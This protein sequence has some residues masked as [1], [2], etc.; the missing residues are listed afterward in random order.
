MCG[1]AAKTKQSSTSTYTPTAQASGVYNNVLDRA[2]TNA[3]QAY[4][5]AM[6]KSIAAFNPTQQQAQAA[7]QGNQ[8]AW[9]GD[10]GQAGD[11]ISGAGAALT[12]DDISRYT[13]PWQQQVVDAAMAKIRDQDA[14]QQREFT[15]G[16]VSQGG[17]GGNGVF[18][19]RAQ[20]AA[21]Q[22]ENRNA[23]IA[24]LMSQGFT[25][26][27]AAAQAD[28]TR[29][30]AA[31]QSMANLGAQRSQ[32]GYNDAAALGASGQQQQQQTQAELDA[33]QANAQQA[34][35]WDKQNTQWLAGIGAGIAPLTGGTTT[36]SG[37]ASTSQGKGIGN[38][39]GAGISAASM[40]SDERAK[41][42]KMPIGKTFDGQTI[43]KYNYAGD[44]RTQIGLI[45]QDVEQSHPDAVSE[46]GDGMKMVDYDRALPDEGF[47]DGGSVFG[48]YAT[49]MPW[50]S[51]NPANPVVPQAPSM[52]APSGEQ[53]G[54]GGL[55]DAMTMGKK[56][57]AGLDS[58]FRNSDGA[59]G[60]GA[61][62]VPTSSLGAGTGGGGWLSGIGSALGF[63]DGGAVEDEFRPSYAGRA[64]PEEMN[65][66]EMVE[67]GGRDIQGPMT[68]SGE[69]AQ[70]PRQI[71]PATARQP[72]F[73]VAPLR[74]GASIA[75]QRT[76][77][78]DYF[79]AMLR[80]YDGDRD[81]ARIAYNGG[82]ARA[83]AW[84]KAGRD[85]SVIPRESADYYKK[86]GA[87]LSPGQATARNAAGTVAAGGDG[88]ATAPLV[89][90]GMNG[91]TTDGTRYADKGDRA[92]GGLLKSLFGVEFNPL[93][94][95]EDERRAL[96][97]AGL[98]MMSHGDIGRGGLQGMSYLAGTEER[99]RDAKK[100]AWKL[101]QQ[102][103]ADERAVQAAARAERRED[104]LT[105][106]DEK[107]LDLAQKE[108]DLKTKIGGGHSDQHKRAID[109]GL[110]PGTPEYQEYVL[111]GPEK[112]AKAAELPGEIGARI[113]L[114]REFEKDIPSL[115]GKIEKFGATDYADLAVNRGEAGR[116]WRR[117]ESGRDALVRGLTGAGIGVAEAENQ[118]A[119]YQIGVTD[120]P[121]TM[122]NKLDSLAR[123]LRAVEE[124]A[125]TAK[126]GEMAREYVRRDTP[127]NTRPKG[128][129]NNEARVEA[130]K[131]I[132]A[133]RPREAVVKRLEGWGIST[134]GL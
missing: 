50:A 53:K 89:Q 13:N 46:R 101:K 31:G 98:G 84:L 91:S 108:F 72:G 94:L 117:I 45:A 65:A 123:D 8:G 119:R 70:G 64:T 104:R 92:A 120:T 107:R 103:G 27:Q 48:G 42:N 28:K 55:G 52:S 74:Q 3:N 11:M 67:S 73:G 25:Q 10:F 5:P 126:T 54:D 36:S 49:A 9:Q 6:G 2:Q 82:P 56:A 112:A 118:A 134:G 132:A 81:A 19:G 129:S 24:N 43:W 69:R 35:L 41:E 63:A 59:G 96:L 12:G 95:N 133:G 17:L 100:E 1:G 7:V 44:P 130:R 110:T 15:A 61:S 30:L 62:I 23:T 75:E 111:R 99:D 40:L 66:L 34:G 33:A 78:D 109:A 16:Q 121:A 14:M 26:A 37:T 115:K 122:I 90:K 102:M 83:D 57:G 86:I 128:L 39:I 20:L 51:I 97:V 114:G 80:R 68:R 38:L 87:R 71:M 18:V 124:G 88:G 58:L 79:N 105:N 60:W 116:V 29:G 85:D 32:L 106:A 4:D 131:A 127:T 76:F 77:S 113:G 47:A 22:G 125:I 21:D 93:N